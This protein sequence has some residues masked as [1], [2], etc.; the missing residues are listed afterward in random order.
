MTKP[1]HLG[2]VLSITTGRLVSPSHMDGVYAI[3]NWMTGESLFTHALPR[4]SRACR[5]ALLRQHP[6]LAAITV[7]TFDGPD[8]VPPWLAEQVARF[9]EWLDVAP[10]APGD[11][12]ARN[13]IAE[14][15][16]M[17]ESPPPV[18]G[19]GTG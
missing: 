15:R 14:L 2:D 12:E 10:L 4:A 19:G 5:P 17:M 1:F 13:P 7:P 3:L 18:D 11:Y 6:Q 9:G 8:A 16:A